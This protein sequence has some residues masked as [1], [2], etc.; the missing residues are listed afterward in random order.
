MDPLFQI[1]KFT[2][3]REGGTLLEANT[4][5]DLFSAVGRQFRLEAKMDRASA[6][7]SDAVLDYLDFAAGE[8]ARAFKAQV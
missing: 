5:S 3:E 8:A 4:L 2:V 6:E 1:Q 7:Q